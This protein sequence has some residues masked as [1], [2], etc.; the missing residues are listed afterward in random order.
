MASTGEMTY[1]L[2]K[3]APEPDTFAPTVEHASMK[4]SHSKDRTFSFVISDAGAPPSGLDTTP[5]K[6]VDL[7]SITES[8]T[9]TAVLVTGRV[10]Y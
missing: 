8:P 6:G 4:D 10:L 1:K 2:H 9:L 7:H 5:T 3:V